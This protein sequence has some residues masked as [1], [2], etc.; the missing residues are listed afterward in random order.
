MATGRP[1]PAVLECAIDVWGMSAP[2]APIAPPSPPPEPVINEDAIRDAAKRLGAAERPLIIC[3]GGAQGASPEVTALS[4]LLQAPVLAFRRGR[5]VLDGRDPFSVTLPLGRDLWGE[6]DAVL[7]IGTRLFNQFTQWGS[8]DDLVI[9]RVDADP[10]EPERFR[11]PAVALIGDAAPI[12]R[13]LVD[14]LPGWSGVGRR[15]T[16]SA[17]RARP[18]WKSA[19]R[20][21]R[22]AWPRLRRRSAISKQ[23]APSCPRTVSWSMKSPRWDLPPGCCFR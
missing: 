15:T 9:V 2:V 12:L 22:A 4:R 18:R 23:S 1:G 14:E 11:R 7:A 16:A 17:P 10:E 21:G 19:R 6:A 20:S 8:D 13:R 5:G 3:G